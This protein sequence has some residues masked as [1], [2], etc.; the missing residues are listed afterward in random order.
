VQDATTCMDAE[1]ATWW[2][3]VGDGFVFCCTGWW[4]LSTCSLECLCH[5]G[6]W[7][8]FPSVSVVFSSVFVRFRIPIYPASRPVPPT[9]VLFTGETIWDG[10][11][12]RDFPSAQ[13]YRTTKH[14]GSV[15]ACFHKSKS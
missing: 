10:T 14:I 7:S 5:H 9:P 12:L 15:T 13:K 2:W 4:M 3:A 6:V 1:Y 11:H 8:H